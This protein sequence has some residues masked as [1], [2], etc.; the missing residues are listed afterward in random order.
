MR[1]AQAARYARWSAAISLLLTLLV[2]GVYVRHSWQGRF[3]H[4]AVPPSVPSSVQQQSAA[5]SFSKEVGNRT[6]FTV[7]ASRATQYTADGRGVL[8]DVW[9]TSYG[10]DGQRFDNLRTRSCDY[11]DSTGSIRCA[12]AVQIELE[13]AADARLHPGTQA[14]PNPDA[15]V[16][17]VLTSN[18]SFDRQTGVAQTDQ[19]VQ[20][21]FSQLEGQAMGLHFDSA[22]AE[23][24]LL[25]DVDMVFHGTGTSG[26]PGSRKGIEEA[27]KLTNQGIS[28]DTSGGI[29]AATSAPPLHVTGSSLIFSRDNRVIHLLGPARASEGAYELAAAQFSVDLDEQ[30]RPRLLLANGHPEIRMAG[31]RMPIT[32]SAD[33][34]SAPVSQDGS[35]ERILAKGNVRARE[36]SDA[37]EDRLDAATAD[38]ELAPKTRQPRLLTAAGNVV[39][40]SDGPGG[41]RRQLTTSSLEMS[42]VAVAESL[43]PASK[44]VR[45]RGGGDTVRIDRIATPAAIIDSTG[46]SRAAKAQ[47]ASATK[48]ETMHLTSQHL[49]AT[50]GSANELKEVHGTGGVE[51]NRHLPEGAIE[52]ST[53]REAL[54]RFGADGMWSTVDETGNV[55]LRENESSAVADRAH[56]D[57]LDDAA[58]LSG[59]VTI[60]DAGSRTSAQSATFHQAANEFDAESRVAT[61]ELAAGGRESGVSPGLGQGPAHVSGDHLVANTVTG[62]AL[63]SGHARLWQGDS[64]IEADSIDL[65]RTTHTMVAVNHVRAVFPQTAWTRTPDQGAATNGAPAPH[66]VSQ[67]TGA[68]PSG[69]TEFWR[70][71]AGKLTYTDEDGRARLEQSVRARSSEGTIRGDLMNLFF[72]SG[73]PVAVTPHMPGAGAVGS[74]VALSVVVPGRSAAGQGIARASGEAD[75]HGSGRRLVRATALGHVLVD[76]EDRHGTGDRGEYVAAEGKFVLS[77]GPPVVHDD[78]GNSTT[79]RELTLFFADDKILVDSADGLRTLTMHRVEK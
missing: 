48:L 10:S 3:L 72:S 25:S 17:H 16:I 57:R 45:N 27:G 19:K 41:V 56:F 54:A 21:Q 50:F 59:S 20:F 52:T 37:G 65:D 11:M 76:Q 77:G 18:L 32:V 47:G 7:R 51:L 53:S 34:F 49:D 67:K 23:M 28:R 73:D 44:T 29:P 14:K 30:S 36:H 35:V 74:P 4:L 12:G 15:A 2:V 6:A 69:Q 42:F 62:H 43:L 1:N 13:S 24:R 9:I 38:V 64:V 31:E 33:E 46:P 5:F 58:S 63:Y 71:E 61:S 26:G 79:G 66:A 68:P 55:H 39:V 70:V 60:S 8:E 78:S 22:Q 75:G 40:Q